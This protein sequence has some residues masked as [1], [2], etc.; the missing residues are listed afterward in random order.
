MTGPSDDAFDDAFDDPF[1]DPYDDPYAT[2]AGPYVLGALSPTDRADFERHLHTCPDCRRSVAELAGL[3]GLLSRTPRDVLDTP[4]ED[5]PH[6]DPHPGPPDGV[7]ADPLPDTVLPAL[8]RAV[9]R[10]RRTRRAALASALATAAGIAA[11]LTTVLTTGP[12]SGGPAGTPQAQGPAA[13]TAHGQALLMDPVA[14]TAI[15]ATVALTQ[16]PWGTQVDLVCAYADAGATRA[17]R[18]ALVVT[19]A[20]G[21]TEQIGTWTALPGRDAQLSGATSWSPAQIRS[22]QVRTLTGLTVLQHRET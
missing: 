11:V 14:D 9:R 15:T 6:P 13:G 5:A 19:G 3:P 7:A 16:V 1:D 10:R 20:D 18:Y 2:T 17:D 8:L 12:L 4:T 22:V 21:A